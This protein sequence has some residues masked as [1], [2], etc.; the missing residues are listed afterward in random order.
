M[1]ENSLV[2]PQKFKCELL[3]DPEIPLPGMFPK[4]IDNKDSNRY[5]YT[6]VH[7]SIIH[8]SLKVE[9]SVHHHMNGLTKCG[10]YKQWSI[11]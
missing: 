5:L 11:T 7:S 4:G 9:A 1:V 6:H 10:I 2:V 8:N 3:C